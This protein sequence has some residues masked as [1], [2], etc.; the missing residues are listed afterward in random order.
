[1]TGSVKS[2]LS[3]SPTNIR[4]HSAGIELQS[5]NLGRTFT[6]ATP[7]RIIG[8]TL[9]INAVISFPVGTLNAVLAYSD[10]TE[11][12]T[13]GING[14]LS[15][16]VQSATAALGAAAPDSPPIPCRWIAPLRPAPVLNT[17]TR[18]PRYANTTVDF[19]R[20]PIQS[21]KQ[22]FKYSIWSAGGG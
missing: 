1:M 10:S 15:A 5:G 19:P 2:G 4:S 9:T 22:T 14:T 8:L 20:F 12:T 16:T 17:G 7:I 6:L 3:S 11:S 18:K 21:Y 13:L